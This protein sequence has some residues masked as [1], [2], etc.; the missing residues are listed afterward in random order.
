VTTSRPPAARSGESQ[1]LPTR[2]CGAVGTASAVSGAV[3][4]DRG[5]CGDPRGDGE[6]VRPSGDGSEDDHLAAIGGRIGRLLQELDATP[7]RR[8]R[9]IA[10][11]LLSLVT[12]LYGEAL[13]RVVELC[14]DRDLASPQV[15]LARL[16]ADPLTSGLLVLHDLHPSSFSSRVGAA[17]AK[18]AANTGSDLRVLGLDE[19]ARSVR[20]RVLDDRGPAH[21]SSV[22]TSLEE[23]LRAALPDLAAL[24]LAT[25]PRS[26]PVTLLR[27]PTVRSVER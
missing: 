19:T 4:G 21:L 3:P 16:A 25:P 6:G 20:L 24:E 12:D 5:A 15:V 26:T 8:A 27:R 11:D 9:E 7:E 18:I 14:S 22:L 2:D 13:G 23:S 17:I 1:L 10:L